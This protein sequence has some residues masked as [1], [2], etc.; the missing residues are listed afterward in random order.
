MSDLIKIGFWV[1]VIGFGVIILS[2]FLGGFAEASQVVSDEFGAKA[3]LKKYEWFV[4]AA[5]TI[6]EK[7]R[8]IEVYETNVT[9]FEEDFKGIP[10][11]EWDNLDKQQYNQWRM[12]ITGLKASYNMVVKEYNSQSAKFNWN[13]YNT[14]ELPKSYDLYLSK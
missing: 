10:R 1:F 5:E 4:N 14:S 6:D 13:L 11:N 2:F 8:T 12:E 9:N 3:S 7:N